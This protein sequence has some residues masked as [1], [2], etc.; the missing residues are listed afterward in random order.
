MRCTAIEGVHPARIVSDAGGRPD[1]D[2]DSY[3]GMDRV[4]IG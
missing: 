1:S 3:A 2:L 4:G